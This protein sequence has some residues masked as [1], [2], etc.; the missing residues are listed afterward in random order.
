MNASFVRQK[1]ELARRA[2]CL[3]LLYAAYTGREFVEESIEGMEQVQDAERFKMRIQAEAVTILHW[4]TFAPF[5]KPFVSMPLRFR[6]TVL[7]NADDRTLERILAYLTRPHRSMDYAWL[8]PSLQRLRD[9]MV[10]RNLPPPLW[11]HVA[12]HPEALDDDNNIVEHDQ[13]I[14]LENDNDNDIVEHD[15][16]IG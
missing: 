14:A 13:Q 16:Q 10:S 11:L 15:Q 9:S 3:E 1:D 5:L 7:S 12:M 6:R 4:C 8:Q 2:N